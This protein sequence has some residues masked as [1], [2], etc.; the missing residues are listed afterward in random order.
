MS[1]FG[2]IPVPGRLGIE[3]YEEYYYP[4][5]AETVSVGNFDQTFRVVA[6]RRGGV[7]F[8][9]RDAIDRIDSPLREQL[10]FAIRR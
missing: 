2:K 3:L 9:T 4:M 1:G 8:V 10:F 7:S 5:L 6:A